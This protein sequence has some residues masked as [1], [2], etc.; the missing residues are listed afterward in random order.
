MFTTISYTPLQHPNL[1]L[2]PCLRL[3]QNRLHLRRLHNIALDLQL[4]AH[5]QLLRICFALDELAKVL[6]AQNQRDGGLLALGRDALADGAALLE[7]D[8]P[9]FFLASV[10]EGETEDGAAALDGVL[11]VGVGGRERA[12]DFVEGGGGGEVGWGVSVRE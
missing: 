6:V 1:Q 9:G 11:S 7:I 3:L 8:V 4:P 12:R 2:R 10:L 5:K